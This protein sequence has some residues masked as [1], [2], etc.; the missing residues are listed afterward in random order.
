MIRVLT[1]ITALNHGAHGV[2]GERLGTSSR[3]VI[4]AGETT[5]LHKALISAVR[6][7]FALV[8]DSLSRRSDG[9]R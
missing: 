9:Y 4:Q 1:L 5:M 2:H 6:T 8:N 7:V 3:Q